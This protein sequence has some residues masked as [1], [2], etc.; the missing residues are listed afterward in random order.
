MTPNDK[1]AQYLAERSAKLV[2]YRSL[3]WYKKPFFNW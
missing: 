2:V 1:Y 3:P